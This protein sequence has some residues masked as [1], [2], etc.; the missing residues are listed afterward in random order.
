MTGVLIGRGDEDT[1]THRGT[2]MGGHGRGRPSPRPGEALGGNKSCPHLVLDFQPPDR[3]VGFRRLHCP[4]C[5]M[6]YGSPGDQYSGLWLCSSF[7]PSLIPLPATPHA[8]FGLCDCV[9]IS[10]VQVGDKEAQGG[11]EQVWG[12]L[13]LRTGETQRHR[14]T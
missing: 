13:R 8:P 10:V 2:P 14:G 12:A 9:P 3:E 5:G 6:C 1:D 11:P 7:P 4:G